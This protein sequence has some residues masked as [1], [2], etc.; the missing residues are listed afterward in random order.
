MIDNIIGIATLPVAV[1]LFLDIF[2][3]IGLKE[4]LGVSLLL[5]AALAH[6]LNQ[7]T[8]I[9]VAHVGDNWVILSYVVHV[10]MMVP[11]ILCFINLAVPMPEIIMAQMPTML[12]SFIFLEGIYSFFI[13]D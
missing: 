6:V 8:N 5:I 7:I 10:I 2:G 1:L 3:V 11:S 9:V 13:G 12:A 4:L